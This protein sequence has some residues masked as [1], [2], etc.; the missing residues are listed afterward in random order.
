MISDTISMQALSWVLLCSS[1][2]VFFKFLFS[3]SFIPTLV[4]FI[5][6]L[7]FFRDKQV[8]GHKSVFSMAL[9]REKF[10]KKKAYFLRL[11]AS[12]LLLEICYQFLP[13]YAESHTSLDYTRELFLLLGIGVLIGSLFAKYFYINF[14]WKLPFILGCFLTL[15]FLN[16]VVE[17]VLSKSLVIQPE[18]YILFSSIGGVSLNYFYSSALEGVHTREEG[19]VCGILESVQT[20]AEGIAQVYLL[21]LPT[22]KG[23]PLFYFFALLFLAFLL[24]SFDRKLDKEG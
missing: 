13:Y 9:I 14:Q 24:V 4:G 12:F 8:E 22:Q 1:D 17:Y 16:A 20:A 21:Y 19:F 6:I 11:L 18:M 3:F 7:F 2:F 5:L 10:V 15:L 23:L